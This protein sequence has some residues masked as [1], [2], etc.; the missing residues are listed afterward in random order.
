MP[1]TRFA[2]PRASIVP[3]MIPRGSRIILGTR[4]ATGLT[5]GIEDFA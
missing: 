2:T 4:F 1:A 3:P 5:E